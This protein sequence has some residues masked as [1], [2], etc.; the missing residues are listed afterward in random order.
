M[1]KYLITG[2]LG[3]IGSNFIKWLNDAVT[4]K[5]F[6]VVLDKNGYASDI[7][8]IPEDLDNLYM[9]HEAVNLSSYHDVQSVFDNHTNF[10]GIFHYAAESHVDNSINTP[11]EFTLSNVVGTHN[12]LEVWRK[13]GAHGRFVHISTDEVY[14]HLHVGDEPFTENTPISPRSPYS[15]SKASSDLIAKSYFHTFGLDIVITRC[16]NNFGP[17]QHKEKFMPTIITNILQGKQVPVYGKGDNIRE[18]IF[19]DD[20]ATAVWCVF[21]KGASGEVYNIGTGNEKTNIQL[22][23][24]ICRIMGVSAST[25]IKFVDDRKGHDFRY[26]INSSKINKLGWSPTYTTQNY[27][28]AISETITWYQKN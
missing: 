5:T 28:Q 12:L 1:K 15:A 7:N 17:R 16:C 18:W 4:E 11:V 21:N 22:L 25:V 13:S 26:A 23:N 19:V 2:G 27:A 9:H 10:D 24:D 14:G 20:H 3:F 8:N 6:V